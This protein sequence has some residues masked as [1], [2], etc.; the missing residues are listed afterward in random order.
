[1]DAIGWKPS[2]PPRCSLTRPVAQIIIRPVGL[3]AGQMA[4]LARLTIEN[5]GMR[6]PVSSEWSQGLIEEAG[7]NPALSRSGR[8]R[9]TSR[10]VRSTAPSRVNDL[11][12]KGTGTS[13]PEIDPRPCPPLV[14]GPFLLPEPNKDDP[15]TK[16]R[17]FFVPMDTAAMAA[18]VVGDLAV[19]RFAC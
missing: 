7:L 4:F 19:W 17:G 5:V 16:V 14:A 6:V 10:R 9:L 12:G 2:G 8:S 3:M 13:T 18:G 15:S 1:M 11:R